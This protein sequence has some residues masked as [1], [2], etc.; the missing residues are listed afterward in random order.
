[1]GCS[2]VIWDRLTV[3]ALQCDDELAREKRVATQHWRCTEKLLID[4]LDALPNEMRLLRAAADPTAIRDRLHRL[5]ASAGFCGT[6]A[7]ALAI[8]DLRR[9]HE[10]A[11]FCS[12][13]SIDRFLRV[14]MQTREV[15]AL[16][17]PSTATDPAVSSM[18]R[19]A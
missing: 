13:D 18:N 10:H 4:E 1:M 9:D 2:P 11:R 14:C 15:L 5:D 6:P 16:S 17:W 12:D 7:L 3:L 19:L 8:A